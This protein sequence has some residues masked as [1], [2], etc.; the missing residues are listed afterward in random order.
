MLYA[1]TGMMPKNHRR[2]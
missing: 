2:L 1:S